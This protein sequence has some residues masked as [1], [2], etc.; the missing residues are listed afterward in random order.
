M[1]DFGLLAEL[2]HLRE[3]VR[4][5]DVQEREGDLAAEG[6][7]GEPDEDVGVLAHGPGHADGAEVGEGFAEDVDRRL[8]EAR[9]VVVLGVAGHV[10]KKEV[11]LRSAD[12]GLRIRG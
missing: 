5:V 7:T 11:G 3:L 1:D 6:L 4:R 8:F 9:E 2:V 12:Y 10:A